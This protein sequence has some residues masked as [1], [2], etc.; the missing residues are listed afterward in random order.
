MNC[1]LI[2]EVPKFLAPFPSETSNAIQIE[3]PFDVNHPVIIPLKLTRVTSYFNVRKPTQEEYEDQN[4]L[5]IKITAEDPSWDPLSSEFSRQAQS[6]FDYRG[7]FVSPNTPAKGQLFMNSV[8]SY[9]Y[10]APDATDDDSYA[11][12]LESFVNISSLQIAQ[13]NIKE[14]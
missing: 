6:M 11:T 4:I 10:D 14:I 3:N 13:V 1:V 2:N 5:K 8:T 7:W 12:V 9:A